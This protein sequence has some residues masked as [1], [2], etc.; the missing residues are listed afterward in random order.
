[1]NNYFVAG[2]ALASSITF[3]LGIILVAWY[4]CKGSNDGI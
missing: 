4:L 1:M 3:I 2:L